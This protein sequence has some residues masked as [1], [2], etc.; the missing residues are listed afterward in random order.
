MVP[1]W[2]LLAVVGGLFSQVFNYICRYVLKRKDDDAIAWAWFYEI[3]RLPIFLFI[4]FFDFKLEITAYS[5]I[6]LLV[7][8]LTEYISVYAY[9]K[10]HNLSEL[11]ITTILSRARL[12][13]L[14]LLAFF[15][16]GETLKLTDYLGIFLL[17]IGLSITVAPNRWF[18]DKGAMFAQL[19][20]LVTAI[21]VLA[22][23]MAVPYA[24]PSVILVCY[25]L[26]SVLMFPIFMKNPIQ[27]LKDS[28][29]QNF[30]LKMIA[31][32]ASVGAGYV[33]L[34][35]LQTGEVSK[36]NAIYQAMMIT[37][38]IAG[39]IFLKERKNIFRKLLGTA[40]AVIAIFFL[41]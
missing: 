36:V 29:S 2:V 7:I 33:L 41:T 20:A 18:I 21:N 12:I 40:L 35:A 25:S 8:G 15:I 28:A 31:V 16:I 1:N 19:G 27:R 17:F 11:S 23:K 6:L 4:A 13:W 30:P 5:I 38:V 22:Q 37:G 32:L 26:I 39:I 34:F 3:L 24:S 14:P 10:M 9:M